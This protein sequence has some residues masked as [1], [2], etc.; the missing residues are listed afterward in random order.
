MM[1]D[2]IEQIGQLDP[3]SSPATMSEITESAEFVLDYTSIPD[4]QTQIPV[5]NSEKISDEYQEASYLIPKRVLVK[6]YRLK[7]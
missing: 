7:K 3:M 6:R 2:F 4:S 1:P 5:P